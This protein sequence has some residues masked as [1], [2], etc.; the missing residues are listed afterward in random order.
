MVETALSNTRPFSRYLSHQRKCLK[1]RRTLTTKEMQSPTITTIQTQTPSTGK[2]SPMAA[3]PIE[4]PATFLPKLRFGTSSIDA[5]IAMAIPER[6]CEITSSTLVSILRLR[7]LLRAA[8]TAEP[9]HNVDERDCEITHAE[10]PDDQ[11]ENSR[12]ADE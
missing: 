11:F 7:I 2:N 4:M 1:P 10:S 8:R 3:Q 6:M 9:A 12:Y 5:A